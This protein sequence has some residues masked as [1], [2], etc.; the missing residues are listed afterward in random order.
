[1]DFTNLPPEKPEFNFENK[2]KVENKKSEKL[3]SLKYVVIISIISGFLA[4][5]IGSLYIYSELKE[6]VKKVNNDSVAQL[7]DKNGKYAPQTSQEELIIKA[8][9][10]SSP[11][12]V[13]IVI[14]KNVVIN[15]PYI[16]DPFS[17]FE[18]FFGPSLKFNAP[19]A[20]EPIYKK[21]EVGGGTG[22][23]ISSDGMI[24]TNKHVVIEKDA[25]YTVLTNDGKKFP[26]KVLARDP[27]Q[28]LAILK[29]DQDKAKQKVDS[30]PVVTLGNS[31]N[32]EL[33]QTAVAI[34]NALGEYKNTISVGVISG[35]S[36]SIT[37]SG[38][39][40][41]ETLE[42]II[43]T[44]TAINEGNS[45]GPLLNLKGEVIGINTA[46][47]LDAQSIGFAI[48]INKAKRD[49]EQIK[50]MGK[51]VYPF[52]GVRY[53]L[54]DEEIKEKK[55]LNIDYGALVT[56]G[57]KNELAV[58]PKS[59]SDKAGIKEGDIILEIAGEKISIKNSLGSIIAKFNPGDKI[60]VK[61][62]RD[63]EEKTLEV[64]LDERPE[65]K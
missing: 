42:D 17:G 9:K 16:Y 22:V 33:G 5:G 58:Y 11:A 62:L 55:E 6:Y 35:L 49:I 64:V 26:A 53:V 10:D 36:R 52:L 44:D 32:I 21:Q 15:Q 27:V 50:T 45:G 24:L 63:K 13:S 65:D 38:G 1:M 8:V 18:D 19:Q 56:R 25:E 43:Q 39:G 61:I 31:D 48:P 12:V 46:V 23:I 2:S 51:I 47:V 57:G 28:D 29:I 37:A 30:F 14:S 7:T 4:G 40:F 60:Q 34:G 59:A 3:F 54:I 41:A 20:E